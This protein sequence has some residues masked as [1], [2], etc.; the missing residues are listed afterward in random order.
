[1][2][3]RTVAVLAVAA[4]TIVGLV[5]CGGDDDTGR[6][7]GDATATTTAGRGTEGGLTVEASEYKFAGVGATISGG[8]VDLTLKNVGKKAHEAA[9]LQI[10]DKTVDE[11]LRALAPAF[12]GKPFPDAPK[13]AGGVSM[14]KPGQSVGTRLLLP[15]G[16][17][18]LICALT[19]DATEPSAGE[20]TT[21]ASAEGIDNPPHFVLGMKLEVKVRGGE[22]AALPDTGGSIRAADY[23]FDA[24]GL[25][26]GDNEV[27]FTNKGTQLHHFV[28]SA[29]AEG[30]TE[31]QAIDAYRKL[32]EAEARR[33]PPPTG[34]PEPENVADTIPVDNGF[35]ETVRFTL[36]PDRTY[37]LLC[38]I[39]DR[40]GGAPHAFSH[41]MV[42]TFT[43][44]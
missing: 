16:N 18:A 26:S 34:V 1:M 21:T 4:F 31:A 30:V 42:K 13:V 6:P 17:Y 10:G 19:D 11:A 2:V 28:L 29:F 37:I 24:S 22:G 39:S 23:S 25:K 5:G 33:Q 15:P 44:T 27:A 36:E 9:F 35:G 3:K 41:N 38:F 43:V 40:E 7:T 14:A 8:L 32:G 12:E 20:T